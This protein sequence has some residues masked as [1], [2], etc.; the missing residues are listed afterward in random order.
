MIYLCSNNTIV[1][2]SAIISEISR[3]LFDNRF[4]RGLFSLFLTFGT[5]PACQQS[6]VHSNELFYDSVSVGKGRGILA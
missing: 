6:A 4:I 1:I 5:L 2:D 3:Y